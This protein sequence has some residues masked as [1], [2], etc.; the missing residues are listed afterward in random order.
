MAHISDKSVDPVWGI[1]LTPEELAAARHA[2][3]M[4]A[5]STS[6]STQE[7]TTSATRN[8]PIITEEEALSDDD[9]A[10]LSEIKNVLER[11]DR[12]E[13]FGV[14]LLHSHFP[15]AE[16]ESMVETTDAG[17]RT[18][19]QSPQVLDPSDISMVDT[20]WY[21]GASMPLSLVKCRT[22]MHV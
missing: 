12:V 16:N 18:M 9:L 14:S 15:L 1:K 6:G 7:S 8:W 13:R 5:L 11:Y 2:A 10:C 17:T 22:S 3:G 19:T 21:L 20:Q 4:A